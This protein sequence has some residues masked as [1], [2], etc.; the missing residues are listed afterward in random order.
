MTRDDVLKWFLETA[1][2][3]IEDNR[4]LFRTFY[5]VYDDDVCPYSFTIGYQP[6]NCGVILDDGETCDD[7]CYRTIHGDC[8]EFHLFI[9]EDGT[10]YY[11]GS[12]KTYTYDKF[13]ELLGEFY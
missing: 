3:I 4:G 8:G 13:N 2:P 12:D 9:N 1:K 7:C 10:I 6:Y 11:E 5:Y